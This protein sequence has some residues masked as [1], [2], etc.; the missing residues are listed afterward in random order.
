MIKRDAQCV[1]RLDCD[2]KL[3]GIN[4]Q[5]SDPHRL[6]W[7]PPR[8]DMDAVSRPLV[9]R[10]V[11]LNRHLDEMLVDAYRQPEVE[12]SRAEGQHSRK[13]KT[14]PSGEPEE[15]YGAEHRARTGDLNLGKVALY[16]L[17]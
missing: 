10:C 12:A 3:S 16:Q 14:P 8:F 1:A 17:S 9:V 5:T 2:D 11:P 15:A 6:V 7:Y 13:R 4:F